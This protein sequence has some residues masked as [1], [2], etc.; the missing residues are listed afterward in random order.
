MFAL[1]FFSPIH[2]L[3]SLSLQLVSKNPAEANLSH[4]SL[5]KVP[6]YLFL[7]EDLAALNL[8]HNCMQESNEESHRP[9]PLGWINDLSH[10]S[11][12]RILSLSNNGLTYFPLSLCKIST[13]TELD[14]SCNAIQW[15]PQEVQQLIE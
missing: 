4:C 14:L 15:I 3:C 11:H 8:S 9:L 12:L 6:K 13:L 10:F 7:N 1:F 5:E 2:L